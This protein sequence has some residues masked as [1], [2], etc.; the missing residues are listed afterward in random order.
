MTQCGIKI[1]ELP[2]VACEWRASH[3]TKL[4]PVQ[5]LDNYLGDG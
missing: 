2:Q 1:A 3:K 4:I 5:S